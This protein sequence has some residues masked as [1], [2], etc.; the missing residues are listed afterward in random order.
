MSPNPTRETPAGRAYNDLRNLAKAQGRDPAELLTLYALEGLLTRLAA[1]DQRED[2]VLK[3]GVLLAA[4]AA[5]RPTRDI[6]LAASG[7]SNDVDDVERR[8]RKI[9]SIE[10]ADGLDFDTAAIRSETIREE[11]EYA[12]VRVHLLAAVSKARIPIHADVNFG[13]PIWPAPRARRCPCSSVVR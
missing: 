8:V 5:R 4:F 10:V 6:D 9:V 1:S 13:D 11:S 12:G 3:G 7:F 2:F